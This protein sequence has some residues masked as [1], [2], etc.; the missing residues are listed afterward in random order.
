MDMV[1]HKFDNLEIHSGDGVILTFEGQANIVVDEHM[2]IVDI[3]SINVTGYR[4]NGGPVIDIRQVM[5][6]DKINRGIP[7]IKREALS[8]FRFNDFMSR[9]EG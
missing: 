8:Q 1:A 4:M 3:E 7:G 6:E 9:K 2:F 5:T